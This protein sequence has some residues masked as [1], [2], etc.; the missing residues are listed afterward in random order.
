MSA[1]IT[2]LADEI[3]PQVNEP[4]DAPPPSRNDQIR[5]TL[6]LLSPWVEKGA[7]K[8]AFNV[9]EAYTIFLSLYLLQTEPG[10]VI[11]LGKGQMKRSD[12]GKN[13]LHACS[14]TQTKGGV[15]GDLEQ[16]S[17]IV[18]IV[19]ILVN[20]LD[21]EAQEIK[22]SVVKRISEAD[23]IPADVRS[24]HGGEFTSLIAVL[25][26]VV[27]T[28][29]AKGA[30]P[31]ELVQKVFLSLKVL[32]QGPTSTLQSPDGKVILQ[33]LQAFQFLTETINHVVSHG[34]VLSLVEIVQVRMVLTY[35][36]EEFLRLLREDAAT[37]NETVEAD[38]RGKK[39]TKVD[40]LSNEN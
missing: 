28:S 39:R 29:Q 38:V 13:I 32:S 6:G 9:E 27:Q 11:Q 26:G 5:M 35:I 16:T 25:Q 40:S 15:F 14:L 12:A 22:D 36:K 19:A 37:Q 20:L 2:E 17:K 7:I 10:T 31:F 18:E 30:V 21:A 24:L 1:T 4:K 34:M 23:L 3:A 33:P 8:G